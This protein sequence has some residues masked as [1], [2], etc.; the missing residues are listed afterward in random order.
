VE[1]SLDA[2]KAIAIMALQ[3]GEVLDYLEVIGAGKGF[4]KPGLP[5]VAIPTTAGTGSEVTRNAVL[6]SNNIRSKS[7]CAIHPCFQLWRL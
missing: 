7:V 2:A 3:S 1:V 6:S 4:E 5:V